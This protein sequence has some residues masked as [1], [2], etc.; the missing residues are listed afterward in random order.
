MQV[1]G[2]EIT[3][4]LVTISAMLGW[5]FACHNAEPEADGE[6][7]EDDLMIIKLAFFDH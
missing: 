2:A 6:E 7:E 5:P 4:R 1:V 3:P